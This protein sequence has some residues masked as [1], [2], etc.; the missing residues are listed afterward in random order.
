MLLQA[1]DHT[2]DGLGIVYIGDSVISKV[3]REVST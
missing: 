2:V 3:R 1:T